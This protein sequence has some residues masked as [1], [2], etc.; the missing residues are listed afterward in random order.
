MLICN[1]VVAS[2]AEICLKIRLNVAAIFPH[3]RGVAA[4][5]PHHV[6]DDD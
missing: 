4:K 3:M 2:V 5:F 1:M 6:L